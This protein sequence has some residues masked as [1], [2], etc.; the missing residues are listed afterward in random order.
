MAKLDRAALKAFFETGDKP[1]QPQFADFIDSF[2]SLVS[3]SNLDDGVKIKSATDDKIQIVFDDTFFQITTDGDNFAEAFIFL[4]SANIE[5]G[6]DT[7]IWKFESSSQTWFLS[8][9]FVVIFKIVDTGTFIRYN[10]GSI[11]I[12]ADNASAIAGGLVLNDLY[13]TATGEARIVFI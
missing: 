11:P 4:T 8:I 6:V 5:F 1:T 2:I 10:F 9:A 12:F 3:N 7:S 13:R